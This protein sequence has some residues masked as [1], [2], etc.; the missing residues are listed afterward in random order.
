MDTKQILV[1]VWQGVITPE[2]A[3]EE[4][5]WR[6]Y[7]R[8]GLYKEDVLDMLEEIAEKKLSVTAFLRSV[9]QTTH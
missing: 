9:E 8:L 6:D 7:Y 1:N 2:E 5:Q 4:I 3:L